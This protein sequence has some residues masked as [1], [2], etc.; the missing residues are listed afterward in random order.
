MNTAS[1]VCSELICDCIFDAGREQ[2][3]IGPTLLSMLRDAV[4][5]LH[6]SEEESTLAGFVVEKEDVNH[7]AR[8]C[9]YNSS[10]TTVKT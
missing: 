1:A 10:R 9:F 6:R 7:M 3:L 5:F 2:L 4:L 8:L